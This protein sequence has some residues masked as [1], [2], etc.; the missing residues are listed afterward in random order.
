M[1][2]RIIQ[3]LWLQDYQTIKRIPKK[4][5]YDEEDFSRQHEKLFTSWVDSIVL[6][7]A[8]NK[9]TIN[10]APHI[11]EEHDYQE[12]YYIHITLKSLKK[13]SEVCS[14]IHS[15]IPPSCVL[16]LS[17]GSKCIFSVAQ[18]R[19]NKN[20]KNKQVI[21]QIHITP[22]I[23]LEHTE[24]QEQKFLDDISLTKNNFDTFKRFYLDISGKIFIFLLSDIRWWYITT[25]LENL[26]LLYEQYNL[27][28]D[29]DSRLVHMQQEY[30]NLLSLG[31]QAKLHIEIRKLQKRRDK[32]A[33][34]IQT[35]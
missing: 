13:A 12:V 16:M 3:I 25:K 26:P 34:K 27:L 14:I 19:I 6:L 28:I 5:F 11:T 24:Q 17:Y 10:I 18:K 32:I 31:E 21:E 20:D 22:V 7:S 9:D 33:E 35:I 1:Q 2:E 29:I 23:D 4:E 15:I 30:N 8:L